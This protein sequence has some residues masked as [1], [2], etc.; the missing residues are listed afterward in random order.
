MVVAPSG[1][2]TVNY[3]IDLS[4]NV[5]D[6]A[7]AEVATETGVA[8]GDPEAIFQSV[9]KGGYKVYFAWDTL[10]AGTLTVYYETH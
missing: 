5:A 9:D 3:T 7:G 1:V 8:A 10:S 4:I 6:T 2:A